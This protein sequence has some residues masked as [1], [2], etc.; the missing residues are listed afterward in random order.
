MR[1]PLEIFST[2]P[3]HITQHAWDSWNTSQQHPMMVV[4]N[5]EMSRS[6][7]SL[8]RY[9]QIERLEH[10]NC[11]RPEYDSCVRRRWVQWRLALMLLEAT[12]HHPPRETGISNVGALMDFSSASPV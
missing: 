2:L 7:G 4:H 10:A 11:P 12:A 1:D 6:S 9:L 5:L 8:N 3:Q